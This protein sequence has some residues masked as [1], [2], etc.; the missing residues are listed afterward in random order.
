MV[1]LLDV[2]VLI[3]LADAEHKHHQI[4]ANWFVS[5][6][7]RPWASCPITENGFIRILAQSSY[8]HFADDI[9]IIRKILNQIKSSPGHQFWP[10]S[11]SICDQKRIPNLQNSKAT[12]DLYLLALAVKNKGQLVTL[13]SKIKFDNVNGGKNAYLLL[14]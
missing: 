8:T 5:Q 12:T 13:D 10:D 9:E 1:T 3:A 2:N 7:A 6:R 4:V 14:Q 11:I